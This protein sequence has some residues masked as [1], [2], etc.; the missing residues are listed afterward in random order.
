MFTLSAFPRQSS[1][2]SLSASPSTVVPNQ[3]VN[4]Q[5]ANFSDS[6]A[7]INASSDTSSV[8]LGG[9]SVGLRAS[10]DGAVAAIN[11]GNGSITIA[12]GGNWSAPVII[13]MTHGSMGG[14][15]QTLEVTDSGGTNA[16]ISLTI[17][18]R[19][20]SISPS[21]SGIGTTVS[22]SGSG[23]PAAN[24]SS[25]AATAPTV[26]MTYYYGSD[27]KSVATFTPDGN[28]SFSGT[29]TVPLDAGIPSDNLVK[30]SFSYTPSGGSSTTVT[31][32]VSHSIPNATINVSASGAST[33]TN[34]NVTGE[35][36]QA[37]STVSS[38]TI[39]GTDARPSPVPATDG[40]GKLNTIIS[41]YSISEGTH[42][43][44]VQIAATTVTIN[45][46]INSSHL[47]SPT[48]TP[49]SSSG[50]S[51]PVISCTGSTG[52]LFCNCVDGRWKNCVEQQHA[53]PNQYVGTD[54]TV[55]PTPTPIPFSSSSIASS[56]PLPFSYIPG[57]GTPS[58]TPET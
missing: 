18:P 46:A 25:G 35:G 47:A 33:G 22:V 16:S 52:G 1:E 40:D 41:N 11:A 23:Y 14:G 3:T 43:I 28:G 2:P 27:S 38:L 48:S 50:T 42:S 54:P 20:L 58:P 34:L 53:G 37:F 19:T 51:T 29:F 26:T 31:N 6:G 12:N 39:N 21:S 30:S 57:Y 49:T 9:S 10:G 55:S 8:T 44:S 15:T 7:T 5:G 36:F 13:P 56:T 45:F 32:T 24:S 4:L 17:S